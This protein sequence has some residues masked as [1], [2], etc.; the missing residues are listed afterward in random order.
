MK[1]YQHL[2]SVCLRPC[3]MEQDC[4]HTITHVSYAPSTI[5]TQILIGDTY[6]VL[7]V[8]VFTR[9]LSQIKQSSFNFNI[10]NMIAIYEIS[11]NMNNW[12]TSYIRATICR[13]RY[14]NFSNIWERK[15][16]KGLT[17]KTFITVGSYT[18][19]PNAMYTEYVGR[20]TSSLI[21]N[22]YVEDLY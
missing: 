1:G 2:K 20:K 6:V 14:I 16:N 22:D 17:P 4:N 7:C 15:I 19:V 13:N 12:Y 8:G 18:L 3:T 21:R 9:T 11:G 10:S 5:S